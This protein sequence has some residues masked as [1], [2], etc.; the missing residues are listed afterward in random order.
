LKVRDNSVYNTVQMFDPA[1]KPE[2]EATMR[3]LI[4]DA[5]PHFRIEPSIEQ[6]GSANTFGSWLI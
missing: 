2:K 5:I 4:K 6:L 3:G 1:Y